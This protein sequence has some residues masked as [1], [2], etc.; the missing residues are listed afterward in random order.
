M[1]DKEMVTKTIYRPRVIE[2]KPLSAVAEVGNWR[3]GFPR[4]CCNQPESPFFVKGRLGTLVHSE[5]G[6]TRGIS[7][8]LEE[9]KHGQIGCSGGMGDPHSGGVWVSRGTLD[10]RCLEGPSSAGV[11]WY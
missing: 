5:M 8:T 11:F 4:N 3:S 9:E 6:E 7:C 10:Q 1:F 2:M